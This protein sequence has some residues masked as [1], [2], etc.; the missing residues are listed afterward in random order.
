V[1]QEVASQSRDLLI[2]TALRLE[3]WALRGAVPG[4]RIARV[5]MGPQR[6]QRAAQRLQSDPAAAWAV[7]GVCGALDPD[8]APGD[9]V[10]A[11]TLL[12]PEGRRIDLDAAPLEAAMSR[13]GLAARIGA[14]A[15]VAKPVTNDGRAALAARGACAVDMESFWLA[16][17][18]AHRPVAVLR[19]VLDGP[20]HELWRV[21][22]PLRVVTA[23]RRLRAAAPALAT[24]AAEVSAAASDAPASAGVRSS[25]DRERPALA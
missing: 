10:I 9:V 3:A 18:A 21:D 25:S 17:A 22:L 12:G 6:A 23:L 4:A 24:W 5:G 8:L 19:V 1:I 7:A 14:I 2:A 16:D 20:R 15:C 13:A 11:S